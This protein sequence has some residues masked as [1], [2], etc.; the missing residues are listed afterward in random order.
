VVVVVV[1]V[2]VVDVDVFHILIGFLGVHTCLMVAGIVG[3]V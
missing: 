3:L 2:V 1:V